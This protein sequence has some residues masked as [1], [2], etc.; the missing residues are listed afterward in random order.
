MKIFTAVSTLMLGIAASGQLNADT[1][2]GD[3]TVTLDLPTTAELRLGGSPTSSSAAIELLWNGTAT[4]NTTDSVDVCIFS[5]S[6][7]YTLTIT[8]DE[9]LE[10][11]SSEIAYDVWF[12]DEDENQNFNVDG[13]VV[14]ID[15][16]D[17]IS[18]TSRCSLAP[19]QVSGALVFRVQNAAIAAAPGGVYS[20]T[21]N[22]LLSVD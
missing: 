1:A 10:Y 14:A 13:G 7:P 20:D 22:L 5:G 15:E 19:G 4:G 11:A 8:G 6:L 2:T 18:E 21:V 9:R 12:D 3:V 17:V 16:A